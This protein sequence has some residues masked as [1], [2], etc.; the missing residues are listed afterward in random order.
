M[1]SLG[2]SFVI[3]FLQEAY[4]FCLD[5]TTTTIEKGHGRIE[6]SALDLV[7]L[8]G[9][10]HVIDRKLVCMMKIK[11]DAMVERYRDSLIAKCFV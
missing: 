2:L 1:P 7:D 9:G 4:F 5:T 8:P 6:G 10:K 3:C 11:A